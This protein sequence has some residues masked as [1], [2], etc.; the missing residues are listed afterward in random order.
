MTLFYQELSYPVE[1]SQSL[2]CTVLR[3]KRNTKRKVLFKVLP[4][5]C[6]Q[7][8]NY[9]LGENNRLLALFNITT[10]RVFKLFLKN[11]MV[12]HCLHG[13]PLTTTNIS[14]HSSPLRCTLQMIS[15]YIDCIYASVLLMTQWHHDKLRILGHEDRDS[16]QTD[17]IYFSNTFCIDLPLLSLLIIRNYRIL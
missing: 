11:T 17:P 16:I 10:K 8:C 7:W 13:I 9:R 6:I 12:S 2:I 15:Y 3:Q 1:L 4:W 5:L 14:G